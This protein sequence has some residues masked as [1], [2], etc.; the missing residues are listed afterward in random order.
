MPKTNF[1]FFLQAYNDKCQTSTPALSLFKWSRQINGVPYTL[2]NNQQFQVAASSTSSNVIPYSFST[3]TNTTTA[4]L[5]S[6]AVLAITGSAVG[7]AVGN[8]VVG[9][10]IKVGS[11]VQS[12]T[13]TVFTVS[14]ANA[15]V[16]AVYS[17]NGQT[18]TVLST[19]VAGLALNATGTGLPSS[20]GTLTLVSGTGDATITFSAFTGPT[21][22]MSLPA[23]GSGSETV[24]FYS[25][26]SFMY[27]ESDQQVSVIYNNG[28][29]MAVNPF[30]INGITTPGVF[31]MNG[32]TCSLTI[33]NPGSV[34]AN[35]T[36]ITME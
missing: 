14:S 4:T 7:I 29:P 15:T 6:T 20:S 12:M 32:P 10:N 17:N 13:P 28:S 1:L 23:T 8:L 27:M 21:V 33:T 18:F 36:L 16:G 19:I 26:A 34:A 3:P 30:E 9:T 25:P 22:T 11:T 24:N 31:F 2:E 35:I 5:A